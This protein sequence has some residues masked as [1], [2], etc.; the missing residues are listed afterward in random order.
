V[1]F[2]PWPF[3]QLRWFVRREDGPPQLAGTH[4]VQVDFELHAFF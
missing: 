1:E 2:V 3:V 4:D